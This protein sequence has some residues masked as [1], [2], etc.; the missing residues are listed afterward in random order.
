MGWF[1]ILPRRKREAIHAT[2]IACFWRLP[3]PLRLALVRAI[4]AKAA[5]RF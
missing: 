5:P 3:E 1:L 2:A 4:L